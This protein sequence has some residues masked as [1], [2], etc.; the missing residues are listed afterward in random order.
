MKNLFLDSSCLKCGRVIVEGDYCHY[1]KNVR[2]IRSGDVV[3]A[4]IGGMRYTLRAAGIEQKAVAFDIVEIRKALAEGY[5][6]IRV[7][8]GLLRTSK[9]DLVVA[10]LSEL[11][12]EELVPLGA[13]RSVSRAARGR[14]ERWARLAREGAKVTGIERLMRIG[15][16][17]GVGEAARLIGEAPDAAVF[18]PGPGELRPLRSGVSFVFCPGP[19]SAHVREVLD[20]MSRRADVSFHLF[21][22]PEGG[23]STQELGL[24]REAG[25]IPV[26]MGDFVLRS[27]TAAIV[28][29]G[30]VRLYSA[31][32]RG[33]VDGRPVRG[34]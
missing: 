18:Q 5:V 7:Y 11:T 10:K 8:Q 2:R 27:E 4:I 1:L 16:P 24:L 19:D 26:S 13:E 29:T 20:G 17:V 15:E 32:T 30:F 23:F 34:R 28:G 25:A 12:V 6:P 22:G 21:F 9:M 31:K 33:S 3:R 14:A